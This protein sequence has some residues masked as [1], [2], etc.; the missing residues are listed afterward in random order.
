MPHLIFHYV[1]KD[2]VDET[3]L[4]FKIF[5]CIECNLCSYVCPSK[6]PLAEYIKQGKKKLTAE[7]IKGIA[8]NE[9]C[10]AAY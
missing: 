1:Q 9:S 10:K 7:G 5:N 6:I 3:L 2:I 4:N 8:R